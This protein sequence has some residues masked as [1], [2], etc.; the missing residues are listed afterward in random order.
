MRW[1]IAGIG[2]PPIKNENPMPEL[3][4]AE[5]KSWQPLIGAASGFMA[6]MIAA[7]WNFHLNRRRDA[8]LRSEEVKSVAAALYG[9][10]ILL[11]GELARLAKTVATIALA[12]GTS[13]SSTRKFDKYFLEQNTLPE[14]H[15]YKA[16]ADKIGMLSPDLV[17]SITRF[18]QSFHTAKTS[19]PL[20]VPDP[21][22]HFTYSASYVLIPACEGVN[23]IAP[24]LRSMEQMLGVPTA[25]ATP[26]TGL[27]ED[28]LEMESLE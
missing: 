7:L 6:L 17:L 27:A 1:P 18:H 23:Q 9:E 20:L 16:L 19:L 2:D 5:V 14:A 24:A 8:H 13:P 3:T 26:D 25:A 22:R 28:L 21:E 11:R 10:I 12:Q 4:Y 15:L